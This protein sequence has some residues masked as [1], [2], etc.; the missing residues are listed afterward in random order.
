MID[1]EQE[2]NK[3][4]K[5]VIEWRHYIHSRP[6]LAF[7]EFN[8]SKWIQE[9][10]KEWHIP[11]ETNW[12]S[13]GIVGKLEVKEPVKKLGFRT[14]LDALPIEEKNEFSYK[15]I[16]KG[17]MHACGHDGHMAALLGAAKILSDFYQKG[18]LK[19]SIYFIFQP[20]EEN[21]GGA[22]KMI[23]EGFNR[24]Y[25]LDAIYSIHNWPELPE[26]IFGIKQGPIMAS[27]DRFEIHFSS[28]KGSH[29][30]MPHQGIDIIYIA[31][32]L[33]QNTYSYLS[34]MNPVQEK[35]LSFTSIHGGTTYNVLP[36]TLEIKGTIRT[37]DKNIRNQILSF[38]KQLLESYRN[39][40]GLNYNFLLYDGY[41]ATINTKKEVEIVKKLIIEK[42]GSDRYKE[43]EK[44]SMGSE[45]FSYFLEHYPGVYLWLGSQNKNK[46]QT[47]CMLHNPE[48]DFNDN[49]LKDII[50]FWVERANY[51]E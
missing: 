11:F 43:I 41:P 7:E 44:P 37:F 35:V 18:L 42:F 19:N 40:Y 24:K 14:E 29:A 30:A 15:S 13:T 22:K 27:Y 50:K 31:T 51:L 45:D 1:I 33:I 23:E 5:E 12:A 36:D 20:A 17:K 38:L 9:K 25:Q 21:E 39:L 26:G 48:F 47:I 32:Q 6:E 4:I 46:N 2:I 28:E 8:T 10:L 34:R 16:Y 3:I 49:I